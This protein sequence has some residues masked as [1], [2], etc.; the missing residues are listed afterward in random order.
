MKLSVCIWIIGV[1]FSGT[2]LYAHP[3]IED[4]QDKLQL[5]HSQS[6][7]SYE[8]AANRI[9]SL[10]EDCGTII[11]RQD[12]AL[13]ALAYHRKGLYE[14]QMSAYQAAI[15]SNEKAL[16]IREHLMPAQAVLIGH[17]HINL[18]RC[19]RDLFEF[20]KEQQHLEMACQIL[21]DQPDHRRNGQAHFDMANALWRAHDYHSALDYLTKALEA[22]EKSG[23]QTNIANAYLQLGTLNLDLQNLDQARTHLLNAIAQYQA[24]QP[25][26]LSHLQAI[27]KCHNNLGGVAYE[28]KD[29]S[30][31]IRLYQ[32]AESICLQADLADYASTKVILAFVYSSMGVNWMELGQYRQAL[33]YQQRAE[34]IGREIYETHDP[35]FA[36]VSDNRGDVFVR[37]QQFQLAL[38]QYQ[39]A[40]DQALPFWTQSDL[41]QN[42]LI[43]DT[44]SILDSHTN[45]LTYLRSKAQTLRQLAA[46]QSASDPH[47]QSALNLYQ[48]A[49]N[50]IQRMRREHMN[51]GSKLFWIEQSRPIYEEAIQLCHQIGDIDQA[52]E[53]AEKSMASLLLTEINNLNAKTLAGLPE[54]VLRKERRLKEQIRTHE[55]RLEAVRFEEGK[56]AE[57]AAFQQKLSELRIEFQNF[58]ADLEEQSPDYYQYKYNSSVI[59]LKEVQ[60]YLATQKTPEAVLQY[61]AGD[62]ALYLFCI[63]PDQAWLWQMEHPYAEVQ[64]F[65]RMVSDTSDIAKASNREAL[66]LISYELYRSLLAPVRQQEISLPKRL[67]IIPD[68]YLARIPFEA[69]LTQ[70]SYGESEKIPFFLYQHIC[71]YAYSAS[72]LLTPRTQQSPASKHV[73]GVAPV[74]FSRFNDLLFSEIEVNNIIEA[75][76]GKPLTHEQATKANVLEQLSDYR[77]LHFSTHAIAESG[78]PFI[79]FHDTNLYLPEIYS[80]QTSAEMVALSACETL[81]GDMQKGEGIMSLARAFQFIGVPSLT[82]TLWS[83]ADQSTQR[84]MQ[85]YYHNLALPLPK[86]E[87][88]HQ[89][90]LT[91]LEQADLS[92]Q[93]P[94]YWAPLVL[95]GDNQALSFDGPEKSYAVH[96]FVGWLV[97]ILIFGWFIERSYRRKNKMSASR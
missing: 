34:A 60:D 73:L 20:E 17:S 16:T 70:S 45:L 3:S 94:F 75:L 23:N 78:S 69:L 7:N 91:Y 30:E 76:G 46:S 27:A 65:F 25:Q 57:I 81:V 61:F 64:S 92:S 32:E 77:V 9:D 21:T 50:L 49:D 88:L 39:Q 28:E 8:D 95:V 59:S 93:A 12:S 74:R 33:Q 62:S 66:T 79:V 56:G 1:M 97:L 48:Q 52:Y 90:K 36:N 82:A 5:I 43:S 15:L 58:V 31:A 13:L 14:Y 89:A 67:T 4:C 47:L 6:R 10:L 37:N 35:F 22:Y 85:A 86:D 26:R 11:G 41:L 72:T 38:E 55:A 80:L 87:A 51:D 63:S 53:F 29:W 18:A 71:R 84:I 44:T 83:V 40:L 54:E 96:L 2:W 42:P 68:N 24:I 19:Y